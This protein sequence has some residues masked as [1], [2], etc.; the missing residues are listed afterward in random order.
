MEK[1]ERKKHKEM[2]ERNS[3]KEESE[4]APDLNREESKNAPSDFSR[5]ELTEN[6]KGDLM[7]WAST[8]PIPPGLK[9]CNR[10]EELSENWS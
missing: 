3:A 10:R 1:K 6:M 2:H 9:K 4:V 8:R 7:P 5:E